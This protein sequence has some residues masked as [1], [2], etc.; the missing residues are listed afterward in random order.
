MARRQS[1]IW[2]EIPSNA[3]TIASVDNF[4]MLQSYAA[5][6]CG[7]QKRSYHGTTLQLVQPDPN[8]LVV[9]TNSTE[10][11]SAQNDVPEVATP[12]V[13][14]NKQPIT[15]ESFTKS[16]HKRQRTVQAQSL[17]SSLTINSTVQT[18]KV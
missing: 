8:S 9:S 10:A 17:T 7:D 12:S 15:S 1:K 2:D 4:D 6:Y 13:L 16:G 3:F 14:T 5:V 18:Y 11:T